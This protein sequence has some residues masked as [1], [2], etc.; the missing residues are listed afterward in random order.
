MPTPNGDARC[1]AVLFSFASPAAG[2][3]TRSTSEGQ[4]RRAAQRHALSLPAEPVLGRHTLCLRNPLL[5][6]RL[7]RLEI[8]RRS[9]PLAGSA[10]ETLANF[11]PLTFSLFPLLCCER[12]CRE[13][14]V[15]P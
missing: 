11:T 9:L 2:G 8:V 1:C 13:S 3:S 15:P 6:S 12:S 10:L 5:S 4:R 14:S 7:C